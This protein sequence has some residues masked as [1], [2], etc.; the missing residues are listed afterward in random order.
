MSDYGYP[1]FGLRRNP[2]ALRF[3]SWV[4][5]AIA[6]AILAA[7]S[8]SSAQEASSL[9]VGD[10]VRLTVAPRP[11]EIIQGRLVSLSPNA[12]II[13]RSKTTEPINFSSI[14][15]LEVKKRTAGSFVRSVAFGLLGGAVAGGLIG[16]AR[17]EINTGDGRISAAEDALITSVVGG[18]IGIIG[19]TVFGACCSSSWQAV[20][21]PTG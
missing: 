18:A 20:P 16:A 21:I 8:V 9:R 2:R 11:S 13:A 1:T 19:G 17:G 14:R 12:M 5:R 4:V 6:L 10:R 15:L 7:P 3:T